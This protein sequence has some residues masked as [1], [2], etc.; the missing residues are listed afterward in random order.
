M[1]LKSTCQVEVGVGTG[2]KLQCGKLRL[3]GL[4]ERIRLPSGLRAAIAH[5]EPEY[6]LDRPGARKD[7]AVPLGPRMTQANDFSSAAYHAHQIGREGIGDEDRRTQRCRRYTERCR[8]ILHG[9]WGHVMTFGHASGLLAADSACTPTSSR[10][11][12][13]CGAAWPLRSYHRCSRRHRRRTE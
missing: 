10:R 5:D 8:W 6:A 13:E 9:H 7:H 12:R 1:G 2:I 11:S 3:T 4:T